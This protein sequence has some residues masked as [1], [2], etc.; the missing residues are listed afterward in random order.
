MITWDNTLKSR[1]VDCWWKVQ[2]CEKS[3]STDP[4]F[5]Y[6]IHHIKWWSAKSLHCRFSLLIATPF[7]T[8]CSRTRS[9]AQL[10]HNTWSESVN[11]S[12]QRSLFSLLLCPRSLTSAIVTHLPPFIKCQ[13]SQACAT[14]K[15][16]RSTYNTSPRGSSICRVIWI[17]QLV[18]WTPSVETFEKGQWFLTFCRLTA[19]LLQSFDLQQ[20]ISCDKI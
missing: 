4:F 13:G 6:S 14:G 2:P 9:H 17:T 1:N 20:A 19:Y 11:I 12:H 8:S 3:G 16:S 10:S 7:I 5:S 15:H 18:Q